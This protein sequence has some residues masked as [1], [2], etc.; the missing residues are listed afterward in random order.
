MKQG[1]EIGCDAGGQRSGRLESA[2]REGLAVDKEHVCVYGGT[3]STK[4]LKWGLG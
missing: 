3:V 2:D 1:K 4:S